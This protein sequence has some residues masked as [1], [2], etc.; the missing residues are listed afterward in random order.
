[1]ERERERVVSLSHTGD[2]GMHMSTGLQTG[3]TV[4]SA[5]HET[6]REVMGEY[7]FSMFRILSVLLQA[8]RNDD[9]S[10]AQV[11]A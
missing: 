1:M 9:L 3:T 10:F 11:A 2:L 5:M 8:Y 7:L 6:I 4:T